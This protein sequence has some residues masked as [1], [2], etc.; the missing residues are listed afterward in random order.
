MNAGAFYLALGNK[1]FSS[2]LLSALRKE[3]KQKQE[4]EKFIWTINYLRRKKYIEYKE[5]GGKTRITLTEEGKRKALIYNLESI[6][7]PTF[8]MWDGK[9]RMIAFDIPEQLR[10]G[11]DALRHKLIDLGCV[12]LQKSLW[13]WPYEC[14]DEI[15]FIAES[16]QIGKYVHYIVADS[17]T[18]EKYLLYKFGIHR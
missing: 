15:D 7:L 18:S 16:F 5:I 11:R 2:K 4:R 8:P 17:V 12:Q 3:I 13:V 9:W 10:R 6:V 1:N 14:K